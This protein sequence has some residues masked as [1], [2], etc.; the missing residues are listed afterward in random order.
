MPEVSK[1]GVTSSALH[2]RHDL[3]VVAA[4]IAGKGYQYYCYAPGRISTARCWLSHVHRHRHS[5]NKLRFQPAYFPQGTVGGHRVTTD[6]L[7][8]AAHL[9]QPR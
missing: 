8:M 1:L 9:R 2:M 3:L 5:L 7:P 4:A 6:G